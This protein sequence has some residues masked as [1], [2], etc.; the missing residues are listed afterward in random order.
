VVGPPDGA[1]NILLILIDDAGFGQPSTF[2][3]PVGR[4]NITQLAER[5]LRYNALR[6]AETA[7]GRAARHGAETPRNDA[8]RAWDSLSA[9][10]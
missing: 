4:A 2:G 1:P 6:P 8:F 3:G 7:R 9:E 10:V 5:G